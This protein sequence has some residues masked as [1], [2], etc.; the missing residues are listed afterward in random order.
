MES[1]KQTEYG[2]SRRREPSSMLD[3]ADGSSKM[4]TEH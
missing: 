4:R 3:V 2:V 1:S